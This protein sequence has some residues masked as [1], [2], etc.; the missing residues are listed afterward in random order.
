[1][2]E[3]ALRKT[4]NIPD[5]FDEEYFKALVEKNRIEPLI[6]EGSKKLSNDTVKK[7]PIFEELISQQNRYSF[8]A[9]RQMQ[10]LT[11]LIVGLESKGIRAISLK[12]P[13]LGV[14]LYGNPALRYSRDLDI[15]VSDKDFH[16]ASVYMESLGYKEEIT[17]YNKTPKRRKVF[18]KRD[19]EMHTEYHKDGICV[20]L[21]WR[22][23]FRI[24]ES[25]EDLWARRDLKKLLGHEI[26]VLGNTDELIYLVCHAAG[27]A[28]FRQRWLLD[29]YE[30]LKKSDVSFN[31]LYNVHSQR[32]MGSLF[33]E[34]LILLYRYP[35][36]EMP[37][38]DNEFFSIHCK[39]RTVTINCVNALN[40]DVQTA[41]QLV[42]AL[43]PLLPQETEDIGII[44]RRYMHLLP[45]LSPKKTAISTVLDAFKPT[46][47][48]LELIDLP[49]PLFFLYYI[50]R[51]FHKLIRLI[52]F[53]K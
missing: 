29:L 25:F 5:S 40:T 19:E 38:I 52:P 24:N 50:I 42:E 49:D 53:C 45:T 47:A 23:S 33:I 1:M 36:F 14:S 4:C 11:S 31:D 39:N 37:D 17:V 15:L 35:V 6:A 43:T 51:P 30:V 34:V 10:V 20:E 21:H 22:L 2:L 9:V 41:I 3:L 28:F 48:D 16:E 12:G 8:H 18:A 27:H 26:P 13:L 46:K 44:G 7:F 32:S